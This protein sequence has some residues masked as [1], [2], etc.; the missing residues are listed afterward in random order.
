MLQ[1][2]RSYNFTFNYKGRPC[3]YGCNICYEV[4]CGVLSICV[5]I[6][7]S[8]IRLD[9]C[10]V[11]MNNADCFLLNKTVI[12]SK[13]DAKK[14]YSNSFYLTDIHVDNILKEA[15]QKAKKICSTEDINDP[16][17]YDYTSHAYSKQVI[18]DARN[19][20]ELMNIIFKNVNVSK[21]VGM[22]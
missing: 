1:N 3:R 15:T 9:N 11:G 16:C 13:H 4:C 18:Y 10:S 2:A 5:L 7:V 12:K 22:M 8:Q 19:N 21:I 20:T 14:Y 6:I 17:V